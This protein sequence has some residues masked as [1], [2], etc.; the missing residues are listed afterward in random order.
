MNEI[1][2]KIVLITGASSGI[3]KAITKEIA[4]NGAIPIML[5]R[6][7][8]VLQSLQNEI[9]EEY[10]QESYFFTV[11]LT[12]RKQVDIVIDE[13]ISSVPKVDAIINNAGFGI[14]QL[15]E[16]MDWE[17]TERMLL[18]NI[19]SLMYLS[20]RFLPVLKLQE[21]AHIV[22][23]ASQAGRIATPKSAVYSATKAAVIS[24]SN[25]LRMELANTKVNVTT[26]NIG[27]VKT[28]FFEQAD[29]SG[30]YQN[31]VARYMLDPIK[32]AI[33]IRRALF[34]NK[35]E[36]NLPIWMHAGSILYQI[37]PKWMERMLRNQFEKK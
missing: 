36:I 37:A 2:G 27:P 25:A 35:R 11:D 33:K 16:K 7:G 14:F 29:P 32:V 22:N 30:K 20:Y 12:D 5:A 9:R 17:Q 8:D 24:F 18:L 3:G 4:S 28:A 6:S 21:D 15:F 19:N 23:I 1:K 31:S 13:I 34:T 26:V 10:K